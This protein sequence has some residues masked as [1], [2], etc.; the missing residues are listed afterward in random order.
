MEL[1]RECGARFVANSTRDSRNSLIAGSEQKRSL[2]HPARDQI[3]LHRLP[4]KLCEARWRM[5]SGQGPPDC[6]VLEVSRAYL[7]VRELTAAQVRYA[8]S[9]IAPSH[10]PSPGR[11]RCNPASQH[12]DKEHLRQS[13]E[14]NVLARLYHRRLGKHALQDCIEPFAVRWRSQQKHGGRNSR[15][16]LRK[17]CDTV[18]LPQIIV[19]AG[20][21]L[22]PRS[23][24][25]ETSARS[26]E[27][28]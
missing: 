25:A 23:H 5:P 28:P 26:F 20:F 27:D 14:R 16:L 24:E 8:R 22:P 12:F 11:E 2:R 7:V 3:T 18:K 19:A 1:L 17:G 6:L 9:P 10:P 21:E 4:D 15:T 13:R